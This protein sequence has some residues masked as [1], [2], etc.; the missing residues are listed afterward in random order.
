[1]D[2]HL[3]CRLFFF[4]FAKFDGMTVFQLIHEMLYERKTKCL[5]Y[6]ADEVEEYTTPVTL[7][8]SEMRKKK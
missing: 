6:D 3:H 7:V 8:K 5:T 1:M 4:G 2:C